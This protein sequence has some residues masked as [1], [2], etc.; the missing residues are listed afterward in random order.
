[1]MVAMAVTG[2]PNTSS[3]GQGKVTCEAVAGGGV[4]C[5]V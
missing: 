4:E 5:D 3:D 2:V 1:M